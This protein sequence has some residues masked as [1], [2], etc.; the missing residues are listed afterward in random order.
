MF[1]ISSIGSSATNW[2]S[3]SLSMH[4]DIVCFWPSRS[5]PPIWPG[6]TFPNKKTWVKDISADQ[7]IESLVLCEKATHGKKIF[8]SVHGYHGIKA[9]KSCE[10]FN[11]NF[12]YI[13]RDP[14][15]RV[16][17]C[18]IHG[19]EQ[20]IYFEKEEVKNEDIHKR[21]CEVL[22]NLNLKMYVEKKEKQIS[23]DRNL[24]NIQ[25]K[26][27]HS[28]KYVLEKNNFNFIKKLRNNLKLEKTKIENEDIK[29]NE[30]SFLADYFVNVCE[31]FLSHDE[32]LFNG[33]SKHQAL[34]MEEM[35]SSKTYYKDTVSKLIDPNLDFDEKYCDQVFK[36]DRHWIHRKNPLNAL[37]IWN[38]WP[39]N[40]KDVF[41]FYFNKYEIKKICD[42]FDYKTNFLN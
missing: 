1:Y 33:C 26:I 21:T 25:Q 9:K 32:I 34:K 13:I 7:Y 27:N 37:E 15:I 16:H 12:S 42:C 3:K 29:L 11:G 35:T 6:H 38:S 39:Q 4:K 2:L 10:D 19:C 18:F 36:S 40:M 23:K 24:L 8:G 14:L 17:S 31:E 41:L 30:K 5:F 22:E 20:N 28:I